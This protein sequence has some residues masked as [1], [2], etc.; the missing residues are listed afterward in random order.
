MTEEVMGAP[1]VGEQVDSVNQQP[2]ATT[3][4]DDVAALRR[5]LELVQQDNLSKGEANRK[6][7]ERLGELERSLRERETELKSGKQQ[8]LAA[9]GEYKKLWEEANGDNARLQQRITELEAALQAKD[10]EA[11]AERLRA[12]AI[13]QIGQ[14]NALAPEQLYGLLQH[15]LRANDNGPAVIV[16]GIEQPLNAYLTQLRNPGSGWEHHFRS[17]G[18]IGMGSAPSANGLPGV[19]NPY[20]KET[21]NLTEAVR[22]EVEN[23]DLARAL[24]AEAGRG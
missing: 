17:S 18:A 6:L 14:A 9:S 21:F 10:Q 2:E 22:L 24:K 12:Q 16:N 3:G 8:Q 11:N 23:P 5:K 19:A 4:S 7:N 15:Q 20:K 13:Q 1:S